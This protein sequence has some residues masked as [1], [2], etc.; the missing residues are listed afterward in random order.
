[1]LHGPAFW[2]FDTSVMCPRR[3]RRVKFVIIPRVLYSS[4]NICEVLL[5]NRQLI[6]MMYELIYA[7]Q[8][9]H[10]EGKINLRL[11]YFS[12][13]VSLSLFRGTSISTMVF[14]AMYGLFLSKFSH[15]LMIFLSVFY[16]GYYE[17][18]YAVDNRNSDIFIEENVFEYV[19]HTVSA[20]VC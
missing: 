8:T 15:G 12:Q 9:A 7:V 5:Y 11:I 10:G 6:A 19:E 4:S 20:S 3:F 18:V 2:Y 1:M 14:D 13:N 16:F 17:P